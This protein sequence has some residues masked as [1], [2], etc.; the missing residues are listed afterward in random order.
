MIAHQPKPCFQAI[1]PLKASRFA[2]LPI[3]GNLRRPLVIL[4]PPVVVVIVVVVITGL[5]TGD[6]FGDGD[7]LGLGLGFGEGL[8]PGEGEG[9]ALGLGSPEG[10]GLP[11]VD[12]LGRTCDNEG[13]VL[14]LSLPLGFDDG[15][16]LAL[17]LERLGDNLGD[18]DVTP[19]PAD[20][21]CDKA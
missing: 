4:P 8:G 20:S 15:T 16:K 18:T 2:S 7:G 6:G 12:E 19:R 14:P 9:N 11:E 1:D 5:G 17:I 10:L 21:P 3:V 13:V